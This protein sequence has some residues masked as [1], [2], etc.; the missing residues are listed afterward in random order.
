LTTSGGIRKPEILH[1]PLLDKIHRYLNRVAI[2]TIV[3]V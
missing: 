2:M 1:E 3:F